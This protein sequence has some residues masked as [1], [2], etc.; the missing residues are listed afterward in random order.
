MK[1]NK[2]TRFYTLMVLLMSITL[3]ASIF[4]PLTFKNIGTEPEI[5]Q[6]EGIAQE[7]TQDAIPEEVT[8]MPK[9]RE[10]RSPATTT[11]SV[12]VEL[13][14]GTW[15]TWCQNAE[16]TL[17][18]L[19]NEYPLTE[20]SIL[21]YHV[22]DAYEVIPDNSARASYY[23]VSGYPTAVFD[24]IDKRSGAGVG[25]PGPEDPVLYSD[26]KSRIDNRLT[27]VSPLT[28][29]LTG[30][31]SGGT[32]TINAN[33]TAIDDIP[34]GLT[35]LKARFVVYED[36]N[37]TVFVSGREYRLRY[38]VVENLAEEAIT[39]T[40]EANL[41]FTKTFSLD[42][43]WEQDKLGAVVFVQADSTK[44]I[45][46]STSLNLSATSSKMDLTLTPHDISFS[47]PTPNFGET[48][49]IFSTIHNAGTEINLSFVYVRF[50][51][52]D[53]RF[54]GTQIGA[55]QNAG[56]IFPGST[57]DVQ[58]DWNTTMFWGNREICVVIDYNNTIP[59]PE[60][61]NNNIAI[62]LISI[63]IPSVDYII[64]TETPNGVPLGTITLPVGG[65]V[66]AYASGYN[67]TG[68][69]YV[70]LI[71]VEWSGLGGTWSPVNGTNSTL[72]AGAVDGLY[73]QTAENSS[74]GIND[75]FE[76]N[77]LTAV[78]DFI[79]IRSGSLGGGTV[80][81]NLIFNVG[82]YTTL[83]A[84]ANNNSVGYLWDCSDAIWTENTSGSVI[85][86]TSPGAS[87]FVEASKFNGGAAMITADYN[88]IQNFTFITVR[89]PTVD[90]I[91]IRTQGGGGGDV[92]SNP[93]YFV[94]NETTY[95]GAAYNRTASFL[96]DVPPDATWTSGNPNLVDVSSPGTS[97]T[98]KIS[99]TE[100]GS[101]WLWISA[102]G[103]LN[104][105]MITVIP[106]TIDFITIRDSPNGQG[107]AI[108]SKLYDIGQEDTYH[109]AIFN[110][111]A[112]FLGDVEGNWF[113]TDNNV[114]TITA[115]GTSAIFKAKGIGTCIV[116]VQYE[117]SGKEYIDYTDTI[118]VD[119]LTPPIADAGL[120]GEIDEDTTFYFDASASYDFAGIVYYDWD[121]GDG[122]Y[123]HDTNS[124]PS[125]P[126][127]QP[128]T[129]TVTLTVTDLGGNVDTDEIIIVVWDITSPIA[130]ANLQ[131]Y[132]EEKAPCH[133]DG[134]ESFDNVDIIGYRWDF[135]DGGYYYGIYA[136]VTHIYE[137]AGT[138][139]VNLT[140]WDAAGY[141]NK[142]SSLITVKDLTP[143]SIPK[144]LVVNTIEGGDSLEINWNS[145]L[146]PD[147]DYYE[148]YCSEN[149]GAY[150]KI[151]DVDSGITSYTHEGLETGN[152]Y[153]YYLI[154]VDTSGNPSPPSVVVE[155]IPDTDTDGDKIFDLEDY[156]DD[157]DG[158]SDDM[159]IEK[160]A[161]PLNPDSDGDNHLD[162]EDAFPT[163]PK[164][165]KDTDYDGHG[166]AHADAFP[167]DPKEYKDSDGDGIGDQSD[168]LPSI[169]NIIFYSLIAIIIVVVI[170]LTLIM[171]RRRG[172][173]AMPFSPEP[174]QTPTT[175]PVGQ[176]QPEPAPYQPGSEQLLQ[177][178]PLKPSS[179]PR[180]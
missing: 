137:K 106:P 109:S 9:A 172:K 52:G 180:K 81:T 17:D 111:T 58:V 127:P 110:Y 168:F 11:R 155:G 151:A 33:I 31:L 90:F 20:L 103:L 47:N 159:E 145:V 123:L 165:W 50:Y 174:E 117:E 93:T 161:D 48:I 152:S 65:S 147:L 8:S 126:Y 142:T 173:E 53:P 149:N 92:I 15:C 12:L 32:G 96:Y 87:T 3:M 102:F 116:R 100:G 82:E 45:L 179:P 6:S 35:S 146:D 105:T 148:V 157:N 1:M 94:G 75:T 140:V 26:Y 63:P 95:W 170:I 72:T 56:V 167:K 49:T 175:I 7:A 114:G 129:Y 21:E 164:E 71:D 80:V 55:E 24:G 162:G 107:N 112:H 25:V 14:T 135:G 57:A 22:G 91:N 171:L 150:V 89:T 28:I 37:Y 66:L 51:D 139:T 166:D 79:Q 122:S 158:L 34:P 128:G 134:S 124:T 76:V 86:I 30:S 101:A 153:R 132:A 176:P 4:G 178:T 54:G 177:P 38:T 113:S 99:K 133:F 119:D 27:V 141:G 69:T 64:I 131:D 23:S 169:N 98:I 43:A 115:Q 5:S 118:T 73:V 46:Q 144:G 136:N 104:Q 125:H 40:K 39:L 143:P 74:L 84:A 10:T 68:P 108:F 62:K 61:E 88:G 121:F 120:G 160:N 163:D 78:V 2:S 29:T 77:I 42:P 41:E 60:N 97:S 156:D 19:A 13:F 67:N 85:T 16:G 44:E 18:K 138:Y 59:E 36:H 83:W 154:A 130:I 70:G